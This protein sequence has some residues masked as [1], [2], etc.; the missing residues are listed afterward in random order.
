MQLA[1]DGPALGEQGQAAFLFLLQGQ[2][3]GTGDV[4]AEGLDELL[5]PLFQA[6]A[7]GFDEQ[8][9]EAVFADRQR[10]HE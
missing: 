3:E 2:G 5:L 9:A 7:G 6:R 8:F 10:L 1:G 4:V